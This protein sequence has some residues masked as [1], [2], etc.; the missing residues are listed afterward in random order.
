VHGSVAERGVCFRPEE[1]ARNAFRLYEKIRPAIAEDVTGWGA[2][3]RLDIERIRSLALG[4]QR[5]VAA[6]RPGTAGPQGEL[7]CGAMRG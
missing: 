3:G 5:R 1:L 4:K 7:R 2:E 6:L